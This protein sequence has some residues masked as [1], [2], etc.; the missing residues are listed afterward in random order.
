MVTV[1]DDNVEHDGDADDQHTITIPCICRFL[2]MLMLPVAWPIAKLLDRLLGHIGLRSYTRQE[3]AALMTVQAMVG[4]PSRA[5][6]IIMK[7]AIVI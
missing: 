3:L 6:V 1:V 7:V 5:D 4:G 2:V